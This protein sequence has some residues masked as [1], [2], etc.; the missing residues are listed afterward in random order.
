MNQKKYALVTLFYPNNNILEN[1]KILSSQVDFVI[2]CDNT[3]EISNQS[4]FSEIKNCIYIANKKNFG[5]SKAFNIALKSQNF[6]KD[7]YIFF[8]D[9]DSKIPEDYIKILIKNFESINSKNDIGCLGPQYIDTNSNKII[10]PR[11]IEQLSD[12]CY[13]VSSMITSGLLTKFSVLQK[14]DFWNES[15]FLDM[16]D[17]DFCWRLKQRGFKIVLCTEI[18][19][20]HTLGKGIKKI[21]KLKL[22]INHPVREY[23]QIRDSIKIFWKSYVPLKYKIRFLLMWFPMPLIYLIFLPNRKLRL[24]YIFYGFIDGIKHKSEDFDSL[25]KKNDKEISSLDLRGKNEQK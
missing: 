14:I 22:R 20:T 6:N 17:W 10:S 24:K 3:P 1:I 18:T 2:L 21:G 11:K 8:F 19:L 4:L 7:D 5:L 15:V 12:N 25:H 16:A 13:T 23:Y 9:Q